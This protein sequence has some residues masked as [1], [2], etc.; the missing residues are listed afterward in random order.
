MLSQYMSEIGQAVVVEETAV[1]A[2]KYFMSEGEVPQADLRLCL[3]RLY[4]NQTAPQT[5]RRQVI[6]IQR[7]ALC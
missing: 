5:P 3:P 7:G 2:E 1:N 6:C 4:T